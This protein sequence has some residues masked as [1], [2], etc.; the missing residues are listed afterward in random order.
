MKRLSVIGIGAGNPEQLTLEAVAAIGRVDVFYLIDKGT[1]PVLLAQRDELISRHATAKP[2]RVVTVVDAERDRSAADY[3]GAVEAWHRQRAERLAAAIGDEQADDEVGGILVWGDPSLYDS[4]LR[5]LELIRTLRLADVEY[6]VIPGITSVQALAAAHRVPLHDVGDPVH[7]TT[8]RR[9]A[10]EWDGSTSTVVMLDGQVA[11]TTID[12]SDVEILWG[13]Y[14][15]Q[16]E[17]QLVRG[18]LDDVADQIVRSRAE[19]REQH[20]WIMDTYLLR[21]RAE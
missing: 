11:F 21:R 13:A 12:P 3:R 8:G 7:I 19:A 4:T 10:D 9:L 1:A 16:P 17:Q 14:L 18:A 6:E 5:L 20:G 15:G 2:H